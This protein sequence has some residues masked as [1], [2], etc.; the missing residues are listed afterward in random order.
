[1][2]RLALVA[3]LCGA[4]FACKKKAEET[5]AG[6]GSATATAS[7]SAIATG[8]ASGTAAPTP[9][10]PV[11]DAAVEEP[12][13]VDPAEAPKKP[14]AEEVDR[15]A[16]LYASTL[17]CGIGY[18]YEFGW[19]KAEKKQLTRDESHK[20]CDVPSTTNE[21]GMSAFPVPVLDEEKVKKVTIAHL[22]SCEDVKKALDEVS[23]G[24][25]PAGYDPSK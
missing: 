13:K 4:M 19:V 25:G 1:M 5:A 9:P 11:I 14:T 12:P 17:D 22:E 15:C 18:D 10:A 3:L 16:R 23:P 24:P 2:K 7:G 20:L 8:A 6:S 21:D